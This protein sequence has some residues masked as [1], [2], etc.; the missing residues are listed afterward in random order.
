ML[1]PSSAFAVATGFS[2]ARTVTLA[3]AGARPANTE[4]PS[5]SMRTTSKVELV[6]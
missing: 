3:F 6:A 5:G 4:E 2:L 1:R